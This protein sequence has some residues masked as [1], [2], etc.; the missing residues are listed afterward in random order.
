MNINNK[1]YKIA[2]NEEDFTPEYYFI[3]S[4]EFSSGETLK[5]LPVEYMGFGTPKFDD[6]GHIIISVAFFH[7]WG[8][9]F[10]SL[11]RLIDVLGPGK[12]LDTEKFFIISITTLGSPNSASPSVMEIGNK[13]PKYSI[14]DMVKFQMKFLKDKFHVEHLKGVIGNSMGGFQ[15]LTLAAIFPDYVDFVISLVSTYKVSGHN[16][17]LFKFMNNIIESDPNYNDGDYRDSL[18][19]MKKTLM[20]ANTLMYPF[21]LSREY[22]YGLNNN[23]IDL[24]MKEMEDETV[25]EDW[26]P[27]DTVYRNNALLSHDIK[28]IVSNIKVKTLIVA[29]NQDQCFPPELDGIPMSKMIKD[30]ELVIYDSN[31]GHIGTHEIIKIKKELANFLK[32]FK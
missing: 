5:K 3:D 28:D 16:Y 23:E 6:N 17:A 10:G 11:R 29:I 26:D 15:A 7:G 20:L 21:G 24:A 12:P 27:H 31:M 2:V 22:Y 30:S 9:D 19:K 18:K 14:E 4:F 32:D 1:N 13:F 8:G 25:E